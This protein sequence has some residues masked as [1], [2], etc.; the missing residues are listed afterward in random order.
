[1]PEPQGLEWLF[2]SDLRLRLE[3]ARG[4]ERVSYSDSVPLSL[5]S[6]IRTP[7]QNFGLSNRLNRCHAG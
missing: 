1:M 3:N 6:P 4:I 5:F 2:N 7:W